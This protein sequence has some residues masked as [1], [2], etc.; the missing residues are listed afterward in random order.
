M[1]WLEVTC[2]GSTKSHKEEFLKSSS[3]QTFFKLAPPKLVIF[4][5]LEKPI[6][7]AGL[8]WEE[9]YWAET[10]KDNVVCF[11]AARKGRKHAARDLYTHPNTTIVAIAKGKVIGKNKYFGSNDVYVSVLHELDDG[12][13]FIVKY[14]ELSK[15]SVQL[16]IGD[17]VNQ[18]QEIGKTAHLGVSAYNRKEKKTY[19]LYMCHFELYDCSA[20]E[21]NP[22]YMN[23]PPYMRRSDLI[24]PLAILKEGYENSFGKLGIGDD[25]LFTV[26]D[27]K[28]ALETLYNKYKDMSWNW[29]WNGS[30]KEVSVSGKD[31]LIIIEK[32]Y[33]LETTHFTSKQY[34]NCGT[35]GMEV[36]GSSPYYGWDASLFTEV[37]VG[38]WSHMEGPGLSGNGGN[39]QVTDREKEFVRLPSVISG[40]EYKINYIIKYNG[41]FER[42]FNKSSETAQA[43]YRNTLGGVRAR[44]MQEIVDN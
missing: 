44:F 3:D 4:P 10:T 19:S 27:G 1:L 22:I 14:C 8:E 17:N 18:K 37:P 42:W 35:G 28:E 9:R 29:K 5:T 25:H 36:F 11:G 20:G 7:D 33:R 16:N 13:K 30:E 32:M 43:T 12:R 40:M 6:N 23:N 2:E 24:D 39:A 38:T 26:E 21:E 41:F 31:L 15:S 34:K